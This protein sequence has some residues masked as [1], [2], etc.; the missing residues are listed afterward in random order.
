MSGY[1]HEWAS[2]VGRAEVDPEQDYYMAV[3]EVV[4]FTKKSPKLLL[5]TNGTDWNRMAGFPERSGSGWLFYRQRQQHPSPLTRACPR[6][7]HRSSRAFFFPPDDPQFD[8]ILTQVKRERD[9]RVAR[10]R[11]SRH[12]EGAR[13]PSGYYCGA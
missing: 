2:A 5:V 8:Q 1:F 9:A 7:R 12:R 11:N 4:K 6:R 13:S 3:G 10:L